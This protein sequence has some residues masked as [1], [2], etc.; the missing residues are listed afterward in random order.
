MVDVA[1]ANSGAVSAVPSQEFEDLPGPLRI[2]G[3]L[4]EV[5]INSV[6]MVIHGQD[7]QVQSPPAEIESPGEDPIDQ[8]S[9]LGEGDILLLQLSAPTRINEMIKAGPGDS[10]L[11]NQVKNAGHLFE[12][13][14]ANRKSEPYL[15]PFLLAGPNSG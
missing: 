5:E 7:L 1:D 13:V 14:T 3:S 12:V 2:S 9:L 15:N 8:A 4:V 11:F 10:L 6:R